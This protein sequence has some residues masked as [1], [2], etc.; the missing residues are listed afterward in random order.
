MK[1]VTAFVTVLILISCLLGGCELWMSGE[2][3]SVTPHG[4][5]T[6]QTGD[7]VI[8]VSSFNQ[9]KNVLYINVSSCVTKLI[10]SVS[11]FNDVT[12]DFYLQTVV[13]YILNETAIGAYAVEKIDYEIGTNRGEP[14][15]LFEIKYRYSSIE[16]LSM[17]KV[18]DS[19]DLISNALDS[20][21]HRENRVVLFVENYSETSIDRVVDD[22]IMTNGDRIVEIPQYHISIYPKIGTQRIVEMVF[23]YE[24][25]NQELQKKQEEIETVLLNAEKINKDNTQIL[26]IYEGF[27]SFLSEHANYTKESSIMPVYSLLCKQTGDSKAF[28]MTFASLCRR[29]ELNCL[30]VSGTYNNENRYWNLVRFRGKYYHLDILACIN[31][32]EFTIKTGSEM[33]GYQWDSEKYPE[34]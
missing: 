9:L 8:K 3:Y 31:D 16:I 22:Y 1:R 4:E 5:H 28:A 15:V 2:Y 10:V 17:H 21:D 24:N 19:E 29:A 6:E 20:I 7:V 27:C 11:S 13:N 12:V 30:V 32:G 23:D 18:N 26:S 33:S 34:A 14:V 25:N